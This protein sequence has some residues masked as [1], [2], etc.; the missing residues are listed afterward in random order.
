MVTHQE[1][2]TY[3]KFSRM[4]NRL[5]SFYTN[6]SSQIRHFCLSS[7]FFRHGIYFIYICSILGWDDKF[8]QVQHG[9]GFQFPAGIPILLCSPE[10]LQAEQRV[11]YNR[12]EVTA[13]NWP[14]CMK[15]TAQK[16]RHNSETNLCTYKDFIY[17]L[18]EL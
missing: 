17:M 6:C 18:K 7:S 8:W 10:F 11:V 1:S 16:G 4:S 14:A 13:I 15:L 5:L 9:L 12:H 2:I 3:L